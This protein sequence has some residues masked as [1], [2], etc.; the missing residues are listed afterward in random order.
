MRVKAECL[1]GLN[2]DEQLR[3]HWLYLR[4]NFAE[5][6]KPGETWI[7]IGKALDDLKE[8]DDAEDALRRAVEEAPDSA[9]AH[10]ELAKFLSDRAGKDPQV[11]EEVLRE[12]QTAIDLNPL[13]YKAHFAYGEL[14]AE[15]KEYESAERSMQRAID[16]YTEQKDS[17]KPKYYEGLFGVLGKQGKLNEALAAIEQ[18]IDAA[19]QDERKKDTAEYQVKK[20]ELLIEMKEYKA[21]VKVLEEAASVLKDDDLDPYV[22]L[23]EAHLRLGQ[24]DAAGEIVNEI[25]DETEKR[26]KAAARVIE[27]TAGSKQ[28]YLEELK[29]LLKIDSSSR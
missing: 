27:V 28:A 14:L 21:A 13:L 22:L 15:R 12:Y 16:T 11:R 9:D 19:R 20:A 29:R 18:A 26:V 17:E 1:H 4:D 2:K 25:F 5:R 24:K 23:V 3:D 10:Y 6:F 8:Y 7:G